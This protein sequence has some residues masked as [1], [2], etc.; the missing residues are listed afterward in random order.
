VKDVGGLCPPHPL[1]LTGHK[2]PRPWRAGAFLRS[3][4]LG[5]TTNYT[6]Q[7]EWEKGCPFAAMASFGGTTNCTKR[8]KW[9]KGY[10]F[11]FESPQPTR[12][13]RSGGTWYNWAA[14]G[15]VGKLVFHGVWD[16]V[17]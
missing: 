14:L 11:R 9:E 15:I 12:V 1:M 5:R 7:H 8:R 10:P 6:N 13:A 3:R 17:S 16:I 4:S 2:L